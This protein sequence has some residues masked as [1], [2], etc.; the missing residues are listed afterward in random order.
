MDKSGEPYVRDF[1]PQLFNPKNQ[2]GSHEGW[3][4]NLRRDAVRQKLLQQWMSTASQTSTGR[5]I[6]ALI[7]P[8]TFGPAPKHFGFIYTTTTIYNTLDWPACVVPVTRV[9]PAKDGIDAD[10]QAASGIDQQIHDQYIPEHFTDLPCS[11]QVVGRR[12]SE[13][14]L[15][16]ITEVVDAAVKGAR[17]KH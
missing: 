1:L 8:A 12:F 5:P 6:D 3:R 2:I 11:V 10:F 17:F 15:L 4:L 9:D 7:S 13:E 16:K 14:A